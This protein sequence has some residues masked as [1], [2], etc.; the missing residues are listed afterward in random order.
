MLAVRNLKNM[1][2]TVQS[3]AI[4][5]TIIYILFVILL[6]FMRQ[7]SRRLETLERNYVA[8][9]TH[10][11]K[12]PIASVRALTEALI[13]VVPAESDKQQPYFGM[14]L[15]EVNTQ[16]HMVQEILEL[17]RLQSGGADFSS[18]RF[19][20]SEAF[21]E[22]FD[23]YTTLC[24]FGQ[25]HFEISEEIE[26]LPDLFS[27]KKFIVEIMDILLEN[28][29]KYVEDNDKGIQVSVR[30][31]NKKAIFCVYDAGSVIDSKDL[32]NVF[33]RF[34]SGK[35]SEGK[36][37]TGLGLSIAK[38]ICDSLHERIWL[39]SSEGYGTSA[40]FTVSLA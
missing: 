25:I 38:S 13:D 40:Y 35:N 20:A 28:A 17:S 34:Y 1:P 37:T 5:F 4:F 2:E 23:K 21:S 11:L 14:I 16:S 18:E 12:A 32:P 15:K 9:V 19:S 7:R 36:D 22:T 29:V 26:N 6:I 24:E 30:R 33:N 27:N 3:I 31:E 10:S 8:N 39:E